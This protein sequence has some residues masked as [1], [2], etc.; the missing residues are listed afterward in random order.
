MNKIWILALL[1]GL[2]LTSC[3]KIAP[4]AT[5]DAPPLFV[6]ST[7]APTKPGLS[8][9]T[10]TPSPLTETPDG[11]TTVTPGG[12]VSTQS[13]GAGE[14]CKDS[15]VMI[16]DVTVPDNTLMSR[17][18]KFTK[19]WRFLNNGKCNWSGYTIAFFAGDRMASPDSAPVPDA[20]AGKTVDVSIELTAPSVDGAYTGFYVL[21]NARGE[22][23]PIGIEESFWLKILIGNAAPAPVSTP[24]TS[25][26]TPVAQPQPSGPASCNYTS[27]SA[28]INE[29]ASL[30]NNARAE[31]GLPALTINAQL[32]AA[33]QGHSI[34]MACHGLLGHSGS[35]GSNVH[36]RVVAAGYVPSRSSE[37]IYGSGYPQTAFNWWMN[38]QIHR[39]EILSRNVTEMGIGYAYV[40]DTAHGSYYTVN[41]GSP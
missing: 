32:M 25:S 29:I 1:L 14:A 41:F 12:I 19:T 5:T 18:E 17:G 4:E 38:D 2:T 40:A 30:I 13:A 31:N 6:T 8:L 28:Y 3:V 34:D 27:S 24:S 33:A 39:D 9:P 7:L 21:K 37:I 36:E 15:A 26:G 22:T 23:L 20:E 10:M 11:S 35:D 16:E